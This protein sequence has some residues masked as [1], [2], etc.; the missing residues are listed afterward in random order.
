M[1]KIGEHNKAFFN[2]TYGTV[3]VRTLMDEGLPGGIIMFC[4]SAGGPWQLS[5]EAYRSKKIHY[6]HFYH[7]VAFER[8]AIF[9]TY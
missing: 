5:L 2:R 6:M 8:N 1:K 7:T 3:L 4:F 9:A